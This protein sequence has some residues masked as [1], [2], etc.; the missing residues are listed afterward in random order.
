MY[1]VNNQK[2]TVDDAPAA[3]DKQ[4]LEQHDLK[5]SPFKM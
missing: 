2:G 1:I 4:G 3:M 5:Q